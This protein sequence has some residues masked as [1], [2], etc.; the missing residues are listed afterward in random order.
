MKAVDPSNKRKNNM[1]GSSKQKKAL[2]V[3]M[4]KYFTEKGYFVTPNEFDKDPDR[5]ELVKVATVKKIFVSW[6]Q[7]IEFT[8]SFCWDDM[9][10]LTTTK[11]EVPAKP[12]AKA[13][14]KAQ[15][16]EDEGVDGKDI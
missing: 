6:S 8:K 9:R 5:P 13:A 11:P 10:G 4:A 16:A 14:K 12:A 1:A 3:K 7:M 15:S 2:A